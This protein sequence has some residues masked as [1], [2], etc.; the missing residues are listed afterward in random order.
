MSQKFLSKRTSGILLHITSL[1]S[2]YGIGDLGPEAFK[3]VD[4]L[5]AS[6]QV[7]WQILPLT[8]IDAA[9][10]NSPYSSS[11]AFAANIL[12]ISPD[13][14][15]KDGWL[16]ADD[17]QP[18]PNFSDDKADFNAARIYKQHLFDRAFDCFKQT[19]GNHPSLSEFAKFCVD[20]Q[21]WLDD[22]A[23]FCVLKD[24]QKGK[25]WTS[26]PNDLIH[27]KTTALTK[28]SNELAEEITQVKFL[29]FM[30]FKQWY[31]LKA[32]CQ[33]KGVQLMG[34]IPIYVSFDGVDVW[35][36]PQLYKL[37]KYF[38]P[39]GVAGVPPDYFSETGQRWGNPVYNWERL[40]ETR[41]QWWVDRIKHNL[42][43]YDCARIDHFRGLIAYWEIPPQ[44][45][46]AVKGQWMNVPFDDFFTTLKE[47]F[48]PLPLIAED[49]GIITPDV[50]DAMRRFG[51]PGMKVLLFAFGGNPSENPYMPQNHVKNCVLYTGTHDN[52]TIRGWFENDMNDDERNNLSRFFSNLSRENISEVMI[53]SALGSVANTVIIPMQDILGLG[54]EARMNIPG[55]THDNWQWRLS[56]G[57]LGQDLSRKLLDWSRSSNRGKSMER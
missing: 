28:I 7:F 52:N 18:L 50:S 6:G 8:P 54:K 55:T 9:F 22:Y 30:F 16:T 39:T 24:H 35:S 2:K 12:L 27:R 42:N 53:K 32:Y 26:W 14:L 10:G 46:T 23:L 37:D 43:L 45:K 29:Q 57:I 38:F 15:L 33:S 36:Q 40:R 41:Y 3:F 17:L 51:F 19:K 5:S 20:N 49:L 31:A 21:F 11:S 13:G 44:E 1:P 25:I 4:F 48:H 34:D 56:P 47:K